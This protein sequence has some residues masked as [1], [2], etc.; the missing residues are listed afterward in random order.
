MQYIISLVI[1]FVIGSFPTAYLLVKRQAR[2]DI[3]FAGSGN[4]GARNAYDV[5]NSKLLGLIVLLIDLLKGGASVL[6]ANIIYGHHFWILGIAGIGS[7]LGHN[8][9]PWLQFKGGRGLSTTAGVMIL[10][11]WIYVVNWLVIY[12]I[13]NSISKHIHISNIIATIT[14]PILILLMPKSLINSL[15]LSDIE[16]SNLFFLC[17]I[18]SLLIMLRHIEP[19]K[20]ILKL[21]IT[22]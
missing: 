6:L 22:K 2:L 8:Y 7:V 14:S 9:S 17:I 19:L 13:V 20:E 16:H 1:G 11:G 3:R 5:T 4:V 15:L 10:L 18:L 21:N 12:F